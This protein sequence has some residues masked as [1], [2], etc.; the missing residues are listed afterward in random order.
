MSACSR[1]LVTVRLIIHESTNDPKRLSQFA[2]RY[3]EKIHSQFTPTAV[4]G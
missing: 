2:D 1:A 4:E 3:L